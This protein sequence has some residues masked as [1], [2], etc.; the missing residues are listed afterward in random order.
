[1]NHESTVKFDQLGLSPVLVETLAKQKYQHPT[2]IQAQAIPHVLA[3]KDLLGCAQTGTGKTA[4]FAL[5]LLQILATHKK[6]LQQYRTRALILAPTRELAAQIYDSFVVYGRQM[7]LRYGVMYGGVSQ[8][9]QVKCMR[10]GVD[11]L[12]ATPGRL[13]D[14]IEQRFTHLG[15]VTH[16]V[17]DEADRMLDMGFMP[18]IK[19]I[20]QMLPKNRQT[21]FFS[22]TMPQEIMRLAHHMLRDPVS[23]SV[24]PET[25]TVEKIDQKVYF[26]D[27]Q[28]KMHLLV[29]LL[30]GAKTNRAIV[31]TRTKHLANKLAEQL[32]RME[33]RAEAIHSN[34]S[35]AARTRTLRDFKGGFTHV[36][37]ATD[38][39]ARGI[40]V[41]NITHVINYDIPNDPESYVHRIGRTARAGTRGVA[42][43]FCDASERSLLQGIERLIKKQV[44][45]VT[46]HK[47]H[48]EKAAKG[49]VAPGEKTDSYHQFRRGGGH[50]GGRRS[51]QGRRR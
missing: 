3:G 1:M 42:L 32:S 47:H 48:S 2:P 46:E 19:R 37:V 35:Q 5:P 41:D 7:G 26:V 50:R 43:S 45:V 33:I 31:F 11:I 51:F 13:L 21:L 39:V 16:L 24:A 44:T 15:D 49:E 9:A 40:D 25:P 14:L 38:I 22:A 6:P 12:I 23:I 10:E 28:N 34:K 27:K 20:L 30:K 4:A 18:D 29:D 36:L 8:F 17:L